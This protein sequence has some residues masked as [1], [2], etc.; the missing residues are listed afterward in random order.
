MVQLKLIKGNHH[1]CGG[2][3]I[4]NRHV[5]TAAHCYIP[6][7]GGIANYKVVLAEHDRNSDSG[8]EV[9]FGIS[10]WIN[11]PLYKSTSKNTHDIAILTM[12]TM[13]D[14]AILNDHISPACLP[15]VLDDPTTGENV[16]IAGWGRSPP[17]WGFSSIL[18]EAQVPIFDQE[19]CVSNYAEI[20]MVVDDAMMCAGL[21]EGGI[22]TCQ[23][24]SGGPM[25]QEINDSHYLFGVTSWGW[26]CAKPNY[27]GVYVR[28]S[29]VMDWIRNEISDGT[30][31]PVAS[32]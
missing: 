12:D 18:L 20:N 30:T 22:D 32:T 9:E 25:T 11:H 16:T 3:L 7:F 1:N 2:T 4:T 28:V 23:G 29:H 24:D 15:D 13:I 14:L 17:S 27:P 19:L 10:K 6:N 21:E 26:G 5:I 31:C 8:H